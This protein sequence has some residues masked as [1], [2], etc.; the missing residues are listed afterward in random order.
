MIKGIQKTNF[1]YKL[2]IVKLNE[3]ENVG[4]LENS[5]YLKL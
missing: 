2:Q 4:K 5:S 3:D 1:K